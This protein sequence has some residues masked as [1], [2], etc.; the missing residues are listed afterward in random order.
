MGIEKTGNNFFELCKKNALRVID[1]RDQEKV[2]SELTK[3]NILN[4]LNRKLTFTLAYRLIYNGVSTHVLLKAN[5]IDDD[6]IVIGVSNI[7]EQYKKDADIAS[8][9]SRARKIVNTDALTGVNNKHAYLMH[10][11]EINKAIAS[12]K[13]AQ[14]AIVMCDLNDLKLVNDKYGHSAGD[15]YIRLGCRFICDTFK[16]S[17]VFRI[18][19]DEFVL[20][21]EGRDYDNIENLVFELQKISLD[22][23]SGCVVACGYSKYRIDV[24]DF[25]ADVFNRADNNMYEN[26]RYLK[27]L[28]NK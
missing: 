27:G 6:Y 8:K 17:P 21:V 18:G 28:K 10:E 26:K 11:E 2:I 15:D 22:Q 12:R 23:N 5:R 16:H 19:G 20:I 9:L 13:D 14:F 1:P 25:V 7:E 4:T 3:D 24:N